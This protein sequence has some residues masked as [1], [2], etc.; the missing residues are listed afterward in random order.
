MKAAW[1]WNQSRP[2]DVPVRSDSSWEKPET[3]ALWSSPAGLPCSPWAPSGQGCQVTFS[4]TSLLP[5]CGCQSG[6]R[7]CRPSMH[8]WCTDLQCLLNSSLVGEWWGSWSLWNF[9]RQL[10]SHNLIHSWARPQSCPQSLMPSAPII[11]RKTLSLQKPQNHNKTGSE[12]TYPF[13]IFT[14]GSL[15]A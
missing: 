15:L 1:T 2:V 11:C 7:S 6:Q 9:S 12:N 13:L 3:W 10:P 5:F 4:S 8:I 14:L